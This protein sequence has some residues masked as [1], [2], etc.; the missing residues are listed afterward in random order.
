MFDHEK[1]SPIPIGIINN[2]YEKLYKMGSVSDFLKI[3]KSINNSKYNNISF[4]FSLHSNE[5][6]INVFKLL[7]KHPL[8]VEIFGK[9]WCS[10]LIDLSKYKFVASPDGNGVDCFRT[11]EALYLGVIPI[12]KNNVMT[13][14]F[15]DMGIPLLIID[16][17]SEILKFDEEFLIK[18]YNDFMVDFEN[19]K[20]FIN[21]WFDLINNKRIESYDE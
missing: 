21:Y 17:W 1:V 16:D 6:R 4:G 2:R 18:K 12:V 8:S 7:K 3:I 20:I 14:K 11:W 13:R 5:E 15:K 19:K 9:D 10:Y